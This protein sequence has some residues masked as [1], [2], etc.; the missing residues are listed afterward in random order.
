[1]L[2]H[3]VG[4]ANRA[5]IRRLRQLEDENAELDAKVGRQQQQLRD[6]VVSR[7]ATIR[8]LQHTLE[9]RIAHD[10]DSIAQYSSES[11]LAVWVN[12]VADLKR[13]LATAEG[14]CERLERQLAEC[15][16]VLTAERDAR[17]ET[18]KQDKEL[19]RELDEVEASLVDIAEVNNAKR[20]P[21]RSTIC[22]RAGW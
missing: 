10:R 15:R 13:R 18:E 22:T 11:D 9:E 16:S 4:A 17:A 20:P 6:A 2:S 12:L 7:E 1:M 21:P 8:A 5:D 3:L 19:R 14:H